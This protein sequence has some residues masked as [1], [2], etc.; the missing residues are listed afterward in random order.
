MQFT[1]DSPSSAARLRGDRALKRSIRGI[2]IQ[3]PMTQGPHRLEAAINRAYF[4]CGCASGAGAVHVTL[5]IAAT[6][7]LTRAG[8][9]DWTWWK[10]C[11]AALGAGFIGKLAGLLLSRWRLN[12]L[13]NE[14]E[15]E[16]SKIQT[17]TASVLV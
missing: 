5:V 10:L 9:I 6:L 17:S 8:P 1:I 7:W 14:V 11:L 3:G 16:F 15:Q 2:V 12:R 4:A 13:L